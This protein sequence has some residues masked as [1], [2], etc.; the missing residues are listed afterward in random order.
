MEPSYNL[1]IPRSFVVVSSDTTNLTPT[2][3]SNTLYFHTIR[4][5]I[6]VFSLISQN[7]LQSSIIVIL[8]TILTFARGDQLYYVKRSVEDL[9]AAI[10]I[11]YY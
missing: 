8:Y 5:T 3:Q 1:H 9:T 2:L 7:M 11:Q 6:V 4:L 10:F